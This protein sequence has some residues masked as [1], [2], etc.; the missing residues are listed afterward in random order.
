M[1]KEREGL[2]NILQIWGKE[3]MKA[4]SAS[5][6]PWYWVGVLPRK[7]PCMLRVH[8]VPCCAVNV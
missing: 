6:D 1:G 8:R 5:S 3:L 4:L 7:L 2:V